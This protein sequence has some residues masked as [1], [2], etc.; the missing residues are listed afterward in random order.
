[1][2]APEFRQLA[3]A[4]PQL[5]W[6]ADADGTVDYY[7]DR[8][9]EFDGLS[10]AADG[11][12]QWSPVVHPDDLAPTVAAWQAAVETG[13]VYEIAHRIRRADGTLRWYLS[14]GVPQRDAEGRV[15]KWYGTATDIHAQKMAEEALRRSEER[16]READRAKDAFLGMMGHE[17]RNPLAA[18]A[19]ATALLRR[20]AGHVPQAARP[21][22]ILDR[23]VH[24]VVRLIDDLLDVSRAT[25]GKL[26]LKVEPTDLRAT[27]QRALDALAARALRHRIELE[28]PDAP[29]LVHGDP[30][31]LE[32]V[33]TNLVDN[34]L[35]FSEPGTRIRLALRPDTGGVVLEVQD[36]GCGIPPEFLGQVFQ[37]F[38]QGDQTLARSRGG[39][40]I[41]LTLVQRIAE[42]HGGSVGAY[43]DGPGCG[44]RFVVRLPA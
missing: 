26:A 13:G 6:T 11:R 2:N 41:G 8:A 36:E 25:R 14:R 12:W 22:D 7:N 21:L 23:Q 24:H 30:A 4:M 38:R 9:A 29:L 39:L 18:I 17:L 31:R 43:S 3:N 20:L 37:P 40:G 15:V 28:L 27:V 32:Q 42:L 10:R 19:N 44:S 1:M 5:V 33:V 34:A 16:L 35:K